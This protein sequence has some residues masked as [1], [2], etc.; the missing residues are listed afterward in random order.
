M[1]LISQKRTRRLVELSLIVHTSERESR[2][3]REKL[4]FRSILTTNVVYSEFPT[5]MQFYIVSKHKMK[6]THTLHT[7]ISFPFAPVVTTVRGNLS[8]PWLGGNWNKYYY[9]RLSMQQSYLTIRIRFVFYSVL[10]C[11]LGLHTIYCQTIL[12]KQAES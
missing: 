2:E 10:G 1:Q 11:I 3:K 9:I 8:F 4:A 12:K 6:D 5:S 7:F